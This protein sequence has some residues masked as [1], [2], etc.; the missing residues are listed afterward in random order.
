MTFFQKETKIITIEDYRTLYGRA[1]LCVISKALSRE[2]GIVFKG[3]SLED[4]NNACRVLIDDRYDAIIDDAEA[5]RLANFI[6]AKLPGV[7]AIAVELSNEEYEL[8]RND[9]R[10]TEV[11]IK[12]F[13]KGLSTMD[14]NA[15]VITIEQ[16]Q[17]LSGGLYIHCTI[18]K[19]SVDCSRLVV[20]GIEF[21]I[22]VR[23]TYKDNTYYVK[24]RNISRSFYLM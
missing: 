8:V 21:F 18:S 4:A 12:K 2:A 17:M 5:L 16:L 14:S 15:S 13:Y 23:E 20:E 3:L 22:I 6:S 24:Y 19:K 11:I 7:H 1:I 9:H 10:Q